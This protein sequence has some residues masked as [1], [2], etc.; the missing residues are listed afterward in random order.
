[1]F[2]II[3]SLSNAMSYLVDLSILYQYEYLA[4]YDKVMSKAN[5]FTEDISKIVLTFHFWISDILKISLD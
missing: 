3:F 4:M 2:N 1:M 5:T